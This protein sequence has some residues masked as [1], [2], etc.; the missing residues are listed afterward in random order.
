[1]SIDTELQIGTL[2]SDPT[3]TLPSSQSRIP[4][5]AAMIANL[6]RGGEVPVTLPDRSLILFWA[7]AGW[8]GRNAGVPVQKVWT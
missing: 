6:P 4:G 5:P 2:I 7:L 8:Q 1:M 3:S